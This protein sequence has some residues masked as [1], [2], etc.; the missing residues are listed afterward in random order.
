[1][2]SNP[3]RVALFSFYVKKK[4]LGLVSKRFF[5]TVGYFVIYI[6]LGITL[7]SS[8]YSRIVCYTYTALYYFSKLYIQ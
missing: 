7:V 6:L 8:T 3:T 1:M 4:L 5:H 2:G